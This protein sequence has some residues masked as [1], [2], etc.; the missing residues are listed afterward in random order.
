MNEETLFHLARAMPP[1]K[2]AAFLDDAC[3]GDSALRRRVEVLLRAH[4]DSGSLLDPSEGAAEVAATLDSQDLQ[5]LHAESTSSAQTVAPEGHPPAEPAAATKVR[6][7]GD[8]ELVEEIARGGMGVV[9]KA[10]QVSLNRIVAVKMILAGQ[11]AS[12]AEVTRFRSEAQ[13]AAN[14]QHP[15]IVAIHEVGEHGGQHYFSMDYVEGQSLAELVR[16]A[17][18]PPHRAAR[19]VQIAAE[20]IHYAHQQGTLHRDLKPSNVLI[21]R[22]DQPRVTDFGLARRI[23]A[24]KGLTASGAVLGT[25]SYMP[26]EQASA[27]RGRLGPASDVYSLGA[28]LYELVTGRPPF[29]AATPIDTIMQVLQDE[30]AAPRLVNPQIDRDLETIILKC[31]AKGQAQRY[32]TAQELESDLQAFLDGRPVKA[33][34]PGSAERAVR[35]LRRQKRSVALAA[36]AAAVMGVVLVAGFLGRLWYRER[37]LGYLSLDTDAV[38]LVADVLDE[39]GQPVVPRVGIPTEEPVAVPAGSY[40]LRVSGRRVLSQDFQVLVERRTSYS[41]RVGLDERQ[42]WE[43]LRVPHTFEVADFEGRADLILLSRKG[44]SRV[45][46]ATREVVWEASLDPKTQPAFGDMRWDWQATPLFNYVDW[47]P[48]L[49]KPTSDLDGDGTP[50]LVWALR[51]EAALLA[52]SG[53]DG[54]VLWCYRAQPPPKAEGGKA[55]GASPVQSTVIGLPALADVDGTPDFIAA[56]ASAPLSNP[57]GAQRWIEAISGRSGKSLWRRQLDDA[58]FAQPAPEELSIDCR[59]FLGTSGGIGYSGETLRSW[60]GEVHRWKGSYRLS[61]TGVLVPFPPQAVR[62][63]PKTLIVFV[64]GTRLVGLDLQSGEPAWPAYD[65][66]FLPARAPQFAD[67]DGDQLPEA[68]LLRSLPASQ[69]DVLGASELVAV[70]LPTGKLFWQTRVEAEW[71]AYM[72]PEDEPPSWPIVVDLDG[73]GLPEVVV[74]HGELINSKHFGQFHNG[75][76]A[77]LNGT[78][79][80]LRWQT[81]WKTL[82]DQVARLVVGPDIDSDGHRDVL[83]ASMAVP[84]AGERQRLFVDALSG[85]DGHTLWWS[86]QPLPKDSDSS[87]GLGSLTPKTHSA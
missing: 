60:G 58:W 64:A 78:D 1:D 27:D 15:N 61:G 3:A 20:A 47:T 14:L 77:V 34:R 66:G 16:E 39:H 55:A 29:R 11:L 70:S 49:L 19:Y 21:D 86:G 75:G 62:F 56:F 50:D 69:R 51:H 9:Y 17:P 43:P 52:V 45:N 76:V 82:H 8:Y 57:K 28:V 38:A 42:L 25:P 18:L 72:H 30:P 54:R 7:F 36:V 73:D 4:D 12:S 31:L 5:S 46:G 53:K 68:L 87:S 10:R 13:T 2:R 23:D 59:W 83:V 84:R 71:G 24:E 6:Y 48:R 32:A 35:W 33:R 41:L 63:G 79:G 74:P 22:F 40:R 26:P 44:M 65:I 37:Q 81:T 85:K 67:L 80:R